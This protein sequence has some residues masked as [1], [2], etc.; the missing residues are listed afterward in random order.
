MGVLSEGTAIAAAG[1]AVGAASGAALAQVI[2]SYLEGL[3]MPGLLPVI[4]AA[5]VLVGAALIAAVVPAAR[6]ARV[7]VMR[8]LRTD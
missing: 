4:G 3:Q 2:G 7:D 1:V 6:A 8:S 5:A